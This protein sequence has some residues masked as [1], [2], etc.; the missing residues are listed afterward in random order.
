[1]GK[2]LGSLKAMH[3]WSEV[4]EEQA[5][6]VLGTRWVFAI[7][8]DPE[9]EILKYKARVVVQGHRQIQGLNFDETF[10]PTPTFT[11]LRCLFAIASARRWDVQTFDVATAYLHSLLEEEVFVK[12]PP[13]IFLLPGKVFKLKKALYGLKQAGRC[14][15][16]HI[17]NILEKA[18]FQANEEDPSTYTYSQGKDK[19]ILWMHVDDGVITAS[20][21]HLMDELKCVLSR[22]LKLK[23]DDG[24]HSIVGIEVR[25]F[26]DKFALCQP[27]LVKKLCDLNPSNITAGQPL[28]LMDLISEKA[29]KIDKAY[30]SRIGMLLYVAQATRPDIMFS[31]NYLA[32]FSMNTTPKHWAALEHLISYMRST[33]NKAL[34]IDLAGKEDMLKVYVDVNWGGKGSRS[35]HGFISF[36]MGSPVAWNSK[37]QTCV[38]SS[39]CQ[40]EYMALSFAARAGMWISQSITP[41]TGRIKPVLLS[42]NQSAIKIAN[43]SGS[44]KNSRHIKR[45]FH[46]VNEI[47]VNK[48]V[49][50]S[51]ITS[52]DQKADIF[53]KKQPKVKVDEFCK[54]LLDWMFCGGECNGKREKVPEHDRK[55]VTQN[56]TTI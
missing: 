44:R 19:A 20:S 41:I 40:A 3:V 15:W 22:E 8:R 13:G 27:A 53:T 47:I 10:A 49:T 17:R 32:R 42:D 1:M 6:Q 16:L 7:K 34:I 37:R 11:S 46:L 33:T 5:N 35:Q 23:W 43:D 31:V 4:P 24:I 48:E 36:L 54:E 29:S 38:A 50:I 21:A 12:A 25:R 2:E 26:E 9:G 30:L 55:L 56:I 18:G 51:W 45:E 52:K 39:T 28:P 14:W